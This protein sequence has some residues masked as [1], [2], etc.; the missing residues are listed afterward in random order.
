MATRAATGVI[1]D[2]TEVASPSGIKPTRY[3]TGKT[4]V[5]VEIESI[6]SSSSFVP[7]YEVAA[8]G[9]KANLTDIGKSVTV[10]PCRCYVSTLI[11]I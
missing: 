3:K 10:S 8:T 11:L 7:R 5:A 2:L 4:T 1:V 9:A 6:L